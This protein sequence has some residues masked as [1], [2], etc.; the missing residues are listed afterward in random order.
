MNRIPAAAGAGQWSRTG[1]GAVSPAG[2]RLVGV[3]TLLIIAV[4]AAVAA[5]TYDGV[6]FGGDRVRFRSALRRARHSL[7]DWDASH[8]S[9]GHLRS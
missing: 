6:A 7:T 5:A 2:A 3:T 9:A 4:V 1:S 8:E